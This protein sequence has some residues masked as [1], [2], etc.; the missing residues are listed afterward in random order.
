MEVK[1][2]QVHE[3]KL[4]GGYSISRLLAYELRVLG[5]THHITSVVECETFEP[6]QHDFVIVCEERK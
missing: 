3:A 2:L 4:S 6:G 5:Q 1:I